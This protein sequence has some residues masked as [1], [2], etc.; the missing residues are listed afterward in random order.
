MGM[1]NISC[2]VYLPGHTD[3]NIACE[4]LMARASNLALQGKR[5]PPLLQLV[6]QRQAE[7]WG[8]RRELARGAGGT[9][10][11]Q[12]RA[13]PAEA[14]RPWSQHQPVVQGRGLPRPKLLV[15]LNQ[16]EHFTMQSL[17]AVPYAGPVFICILYSSFTA[18]STFNM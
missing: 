8:L 4:L 17:P 3:S 5:E 13:L 14:T 16:T 10:Q 6:R 1:D 18:C 2:R 7:R 9:T 15:G 12:R 11:G